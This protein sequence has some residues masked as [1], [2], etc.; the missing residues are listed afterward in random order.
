MTGIHPSPEKVAALRARW[1][2]QERRLE[3]IAASI[4]RGEDW[5]EHLRGLPFVVEV[6][7]L[8][9]EALGRD[10]RG[11]PLGHALHPPVRCREAGERDA[12]LVA[13]IG[14]EGLRS[15]VPIPEASPFPADGESAEDV[16]RAMRRGER[17][18]L[19]TCGDAPAGVV[20][21]IVRREFQDLAADRPYAEISG[22]SV[23]PAWRR[24]GIGARLVRE[25]ER[26]AA[27]AGHGW[28][29]LRTTLEVGLVPWYER[30]GYEVRRI[31][32][33][34]F[35]ESPTFL[36]VVM[37]RRLHAPGAAARTTGSAALTQGARR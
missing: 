23:L 13:G 34:S 32:Q 29:L 37:T 26:E 8:P 7:P 10:L 21:W 2:G 11:A 25:A 5:T 28:A 17:F 31:R 36:D 15:N 24:M 9:G 16:V 3:A 27:S 20:R 14:L 18:L 4:L 19:A 22:L 33:L 1:E 30:L 6:P 12:A 35:H